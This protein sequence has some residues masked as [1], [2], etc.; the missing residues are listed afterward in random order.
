MHEHLKQFDKTFTK[1]VGLLPGWVSPFM[2]FATFIGQPA[3]IFAVAALL[4]YGAW[5]K[6][7]PRVSYAIL[8]SLIAMCGNAILKVVFQRPRPDTL[9][10]ANMVIKS[11]SFPSGHAFGAA[12][13]YGLLAYLSATRLPQ[14]WNIISAG[15]CVFLVVVIGISRIYLGAH[16]PSD[17]VIGWLLGLACLLAII[18]VLKI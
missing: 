15:V 3:F 13:F 8:C 12:V 18:K 4:A 9:Y 16:F 17:V 1:V 11:Y 14:P 2:H 10:A 5:V 7:Q 6:K